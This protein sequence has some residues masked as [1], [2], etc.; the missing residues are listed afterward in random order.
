MNGQVRRQVTV[1]VVE[2]MNSKF[3]QAKFMIVLQSFFLKQASVF[4]LASRAGRTACEREEIER[5]FALVVRL[6]YFG[7]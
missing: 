1:L 2:Q 4:D 5:R 3:V 7:G 6:R